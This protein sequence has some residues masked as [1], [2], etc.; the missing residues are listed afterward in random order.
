MLRTWRGEGLRG[1]YKGVQSPLAGEAFFN[2]VQFLAYGQSKQ[3]L[4]AYRHSH[5][6]S[7]AGHALQPAATE[8][9]VTDY[10]VAG[11]LTGAASCLVEGPV[12]LVKSATQPATSAAANQ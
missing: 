1:F 5:R 9:T 12:D 3:L 6:Q 11:G 4:A 10:F 7:H 8:L 2:A